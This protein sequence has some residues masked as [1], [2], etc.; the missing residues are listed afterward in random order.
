MVFAGLY[1]AMQMYGIYGGDAGELTTAAYLFG[2]PHPPGYP[3]YTF[4]SGLLMRLIP[5]GTAAW[6]ACLLSSIPSALALYFLWRSCFRLTKSYVFS[7]FAVGI[8][9]LTAPVWL[10][11]ITQE[12]FG[13]FSFFASVFMERLLAWLDRNNPKDLLFLAFWVG[14]SLT[15]HYLILFCLLPALAYIVWRKPERI[16]QMLSR[17]W[18]LLLLALVGLLPLLYA[19]I[20]SFGGTLFDLDHAATFEG[21][22]RLVTRASA[23]GAVRASSGFETTLLNRILNIY[24]FFQSALR[25]F[26]F[27]GILFMFGGS[28]FLRKHHRDMYDFCTLLLFS[29]II[30]L[31]LAGFPQL[32]NYHIGTSE[33]FFVVPYQLL[34]LFLASGMSAVS[35]G[36]RQKMGK[37]AFHAWLIMP[38]CIGCVFYFVLTPQFRKNVQAFSIL[39]HDRSMRQLAKDVF[40]SAPKNSILFISED[41][42]IFAL[43][44]AYFVEHERQD[45]RLVFFRWMGMPQY[46]KRLQ[47]LY[48]DLFVSAPS[49]PASYTQLMEEFIAKNVTKFPILADTEPSWI[50]GT[51]I[52]HGLLFAYFPDAAAKLSH[53]AIVEKTVRV[54]ETFQEPAYLLPYQKEIPMLADVLRVYAQHRAMVVR[55][56]ALAKAP[57]AEMKQELLKALSLEVNVVPESY[58]YPVVILYEDNRCEDAKQLLAV[59]SDKWGNDR[60]ILQQYYKWQQACGADAAVDPLVNVYRQRFPNDFPLQEK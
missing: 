27:V 20:V 60:L 33:R 57:I 56:M 7:S 35:A 11:A 3:L 39:K 43:Y 25:D 53:D 28:I 47:A 6:K 55:E 5:W 29:W 17:W 16:S 58:V 46:R 22:F 40:A 41:T 31:F 21:F 37:L 32:L 14:V 4:L 36:L 44:Y 24:T 8:Y 1:I 54:W 18:Q 45:V 59:F 38:L 52:P 49:S 30:Y 2:I 15:H 51:W 50:S 10:N 9:G 48:P 34:T 26:S 23:G 42:T 13:L 12:V 19:P